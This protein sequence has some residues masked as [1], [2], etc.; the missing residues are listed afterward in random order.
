[1]LLS[2]DDNGVIVKPIFKVKLKLEFV[3]ARRSVCSVYI[4]EVCV[5]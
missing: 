2:L 1:M 4:L 5:L 3:F